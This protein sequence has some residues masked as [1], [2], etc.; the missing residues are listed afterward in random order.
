MNAP[1]LC[2]ALLSVWGCLFAGLVLPAQ[3]MAQVLLL[4][5]ARAVPGEL[6]FL[7]GGALT[8][9]ASSGEALW[10]NPAGLALETGSR[11]TVG[12]A[13]LRMQ[14][15]AAGGPASETAE[16]A[17]GSLAY[18]RA[19]GERRGYPRFVVGLGLAQT[20]DQR[21]PTRIEGTR[22]GSGASLPPGLSPP[23]GSVDANFPA[24]L[25]ITEVGD[26]TG[27]L[28]ILAPGVALGIAPTDW[29]RVGIGLELERVTLSER[30]DLA[31]GYSAV[32]GGSTLSGQSQL[33]WRLAGEALRA[34]A[35]WGVQLELSPRW[36]LG[37]VLRLPSEHLR[38][39]GRVRYQ[40]SDVFQTTG[41]VAPSGS[42]AVLVIGDGLPFRLES[43]RRLQVGLAYRSDR[44]LIEVDV[45]RTGAQAPYA[46]LPAGESR[47]PS[48]MPFVLP[49]VRT[50][51]TAVLGA[52][53]GMAYAQTAR[54]SLLLSF[55]ADPATVPPDDGLFRSVDVNTVSAGAYHVRGD[56]SVSIGVVYRE[57]RQTGVPAVPPDGG[58]PV[59]LDVNLRELAVQLGTSLAF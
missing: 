48:T 29:L 11:L 27:V 49:A 6:G 15:A 56:L 35:S 28:R 13:A 25:T 5:N 50:A 57:A 19:L 4:P 51:S 1:W 8:A 54:T 47:P 17:P 22:R 59:P 52:A 30:V 7:M 2:L 58:Q 37:L 33:G 24:G 20:V 36:L 55:A 10:F 23:G 42:E 16:L 31:T 43:P 32:N 45:Y 38:G 9:L 14:S 44:F 39:A 53:V 12:G 46:A 40:R 41:G 18:A 34:V 3:A 26:A 21:L